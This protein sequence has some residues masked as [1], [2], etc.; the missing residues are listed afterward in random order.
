MTRL[1]EDIRR[2]FHS[3]VTNCRN[4]KTKD[5]RKLCK[6]NSLKKFNKKRLKAFNGFAGSG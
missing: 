5:I 1:L 4:S 2:K 6:E 3:C